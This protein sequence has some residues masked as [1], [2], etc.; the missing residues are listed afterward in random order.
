MGKSAGKNAAAQVEFPF[1]GCRTLRVAFGAPAISSDGGAVL[2]RAVDRRLGLIDRIAASRDL[3]VGDAG[4]AFQIFLDLKID[5]LPD[6]FR[7]P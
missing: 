5:D 7:G 4:D 3:D 1:E 2:L 6:L